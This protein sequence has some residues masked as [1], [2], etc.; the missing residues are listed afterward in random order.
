MENE[1]VKK[2]QSD[3]DAQLQR[4][5]EAISRIEKKENKIYFLTYDTKKN[6]RASVKYIYDM[7]LT[8]KR[9]SYDAY[10]L[11]E[12]SS[13]SGVKD[14]LGDRY[15]DLEVKTIKDDKIEMGVDDIVVVPEFYSNALSSL[16]NIRAIKVMLVQQKDYVFETLQIGSR[17]SDYG[18]DKCITT[19]EGSKKY[20]KE[21]FPEALIYTNPPYIEDIFQPI[22]LPQKPF[23][24]ISCRQRSTTRKIISEFYLKYPQLRWITFKDMVSLSYDDFAH[25]L[26]ECMVS[27]WV[28]DES[29]FGT[30]PIESMKCNVPVVGKI[31]LTEPD[32][33]GSNGMWSYDLNKLT[34]ML[35]TYVLSWIDGITINDEVKKE[36]ESTHKPYNKEMFE[37]NTKSIFSSILLARSESIKSAIEKIKNKEYEKE[38]NNTTANS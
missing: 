31:P 3:I 11:V 13:Y 10:I 25:S 2:K 23:I 34:E 36:I 15:N 1:D 22:K 27:V 17:W 4:L 6:P 24:A 29:T 32:W 9:E 16:T 21:Y 28:D 37:T 12:D 35:A 5:K 38:N 30:F 26:K 33:L 20:I 19:T 7:A 8:L 18:F 14:W